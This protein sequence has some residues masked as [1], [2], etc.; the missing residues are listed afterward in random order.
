[1]RCQECHGL[2]YQNPQTPCPSC[3]GSGITSC[4][5]GAVGGVYEICNP[6]ELTKE[7]LVLKGVKYET[8]AGG[9]E[10][11]I[12]TSYAQRLWL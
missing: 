9:E 3:Q 10:I 4:C 8:L 7:D 6:G 2:G 11:C 12:P 1:M 5:E